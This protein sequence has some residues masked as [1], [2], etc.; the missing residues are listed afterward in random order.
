MYFNKQ[1]F[2]ILGKYYQ[3]NFETNSLSNGQLYFDKVE[4]QK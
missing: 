3:N 4:I 1:A 2:D